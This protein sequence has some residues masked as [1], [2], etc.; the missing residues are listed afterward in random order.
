MT[1]AAYAELQATSNF[2]FLRGASHPEELVSQAAAF[3]LDAI[4]IAD[5]HSVTGLV[6]AH[7]AAKDAGIRLVIGVRLDLEDGPGLLC[8]PTERTAYGRLCRLLTTGK[9]RAPKGACW[10]RLEDLTAGGDFANGDGQIIV[11]LPPAGS[12]AADPGGA[13]AGALKTL[14][15]NF[16]KKLYLAVSKLYNGNNDERLQALTTV[17]KRCRVPI[18]ATNDVHAHTPRRKPLLDVLTCIREGCTIGDAGYRL[19]ANA[20]RHLKNADEMARLFAEYP[21]AIARTTE[22]ARACTFSLDELSYEYPVDPVPDGRTPQEELIRLT[23]EGAAGRYPAGVPEKVKAQVK[24][25]LAQIGELGFAPYFLTVHDIVRYA[26]SRDILCQGRGSAA[27]SAVCYCLGITAV[28]PNRID[29]LFERFVSAERGEPPD[30]DVD[31]ENARREEVIQ[32]V[33]GKYGRE[34]AAMTATVITYRT[35]GALR[36]TG[37]AFGLTDDTIVALQSAAWRRSW[38][39][40]GDQDIRDAGLDPEQPTLRLVMAL[41]GELRGFPRHLSQHTGGIGDD[42]GAAQRSRAHRQR[43][44]GGTYRHRMGQRRPGCARHPQGRHPGAWHADL[45][46]QGV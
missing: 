22:I 43:G 20:E 26:E 28:D 7:M 2:S 35:K 27:N 17:A 4:A 8:F 39:E 34:R 36:E 45:R 32:Y 41:A 33:Y 15:N 31:F 18:V 10:L 19:F 6:R 42:A 38:D 16:N 9:R 40:I 29:V 1:A 46:A 12:A 30:I 11:V 3:G 21:D 14:R 13:F 44:D 37:K 23:W 25:E 24:H 5:R